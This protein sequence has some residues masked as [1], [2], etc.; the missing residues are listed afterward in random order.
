MAWLIAQA[1]GGTVIR[2]SGTQRRSRIWTGL[3]EWISNIIKIFVS[4]LNAKLCAMVVLQSMRFIPGMTG[5]KWKYLYNRLYSPWKRHSQLDGTIQSVAISQAPVVTALVHCPTR[6]ATVQQSCCFSP[7]ATVLPHIQSTRKETDAKC[8]MKHLSWVRPTNLLAACCYTG[9]HPL[10]KGQKFT[11]IEIY[12]YP[13]LLILKASACS[14]IWEPPKYS[15]H[16]HGIIHNITED[17]ITHLRAKD[18]LVWIHNRGIPWF[19]HVPSTEKLITW[20]GLS[21]VFWRSNEESLKTI[22]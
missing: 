4:H 15:S 14:T 7:A 20:Y 3:W 19:Y 5:T 12:T 18:V 16:K 9:L 2:R 22:P 8:P 21:I 17:Q 13:T 10:Q 1:S 6:W 11:L